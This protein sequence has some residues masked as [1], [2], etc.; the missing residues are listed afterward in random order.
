MAPLEDDPLYITDEEL[1]AHEARLVAEGR[2]RLPKIEPTPEFWDEFFKEPLADFG[3]LDVVRFISEDRDEYDEDMARRYRMK[4]VSVKQ[5]Q[6]DLGRYLDEVRAGKEVI[7]E[8]R[9]NPVAKIIPLRSVSAKE[10]KADVSRY[11]DEALAGE[12]V[13]IEDKDRPIAKIIPFNAVDEDEEFDEHLAKLI[14]EGKAR[15]PIGPLAP[16]FWTEPPIKISE[17]ELVALVS[18]DR[19]E[20]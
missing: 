1:E 4:T 18:E 12:E 3:D 5:L 11:L 9:D 15:A 6:D 14:A 8:E 10:L 2:M 20:D 17:K 7:I 19:D 16:E 13:L